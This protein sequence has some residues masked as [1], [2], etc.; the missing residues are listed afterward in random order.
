M[1]VGTYSPEFLEPTPT[2]ATQV[3]INVKAI[4]VSILGRVR[5]VYGYLPYPRHDAGW[6]REL[7]NKVRAVLGA[8]SQTR[9]RR[10]GS[11]TFPP[12]TSLRLPVKRPK[13]SIHGLFY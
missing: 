10:A 4:D 3:E 5:W 1:L 2:V 11:S 13:N 9:F 12:I 6:Y 8:P 7:A